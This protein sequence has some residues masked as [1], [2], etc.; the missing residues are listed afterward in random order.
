M[1][2]SLGTA[3]VESI[4]AEQGRVDVG[5][6]FCGAQYGFDPL[7]HGAADA[8][9][10]LAVRRRHGR[11]DRHVTHGEPADPVAD[12]DGQHPVQRGGVR[13]DPGKHGGRVRMGRI[14]ESDNLATN[15]RVVITH[16][17]EKAR[18]R[19]CAGIV[20]R[21][22]VRYDVQRRGID[23]GHGCAREGGRRGRG[24][25]SHGGPHSIGAGRR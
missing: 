20:D 14:L 22:E 13:G 25:L 17:S 23:A 3:E 12:R 8:E 4:I 5:C 21:R 19:A 18:H 10:E 15:L 16:R 7:D 24:G 9:R 1:L 2:R 6:E 11:D